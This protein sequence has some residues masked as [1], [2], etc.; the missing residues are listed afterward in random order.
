MESEN[1]EIRLIKRNNDLKVK[2]AE[3]E[4]NYDKGYNDCLEEIKLK[5]SES[6][7]KAREAKRKLP[8]KEI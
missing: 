8:G 2:L 3:D 1:E 7:K 4:G 5:R 6:L